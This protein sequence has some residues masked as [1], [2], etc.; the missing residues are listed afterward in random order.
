MGAVNLRR[1]EQEGLVEVKKGFVERKP[2]SWYSLSAQGQQA[3]RRHVEALERI[4]G[5]ARL[6][7]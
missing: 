5:A 7:C 1:L 2:V 4:V 6:G 3:L